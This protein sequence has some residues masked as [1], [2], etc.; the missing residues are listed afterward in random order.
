MTGINETDEALV[1]APSFPRGLD[2]RKGY[3]VACDDTGRLGGSWLQVAISDDGDVWVSMQQWEDPSRGEPSPI[4]GIRCRTYFGGGQNSR[5]H[6]ALL[7][8]ARAI[9]LDNADRGR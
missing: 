3:R 8:L 2:A 6:Q 7:W 4:P 1:F 5:T 9:Q